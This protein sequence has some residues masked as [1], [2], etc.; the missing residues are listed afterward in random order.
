[1]P[2]VRDLLFPEDTGDRLFPVHVTFHHV[3]PSAVLV[4][5]GLP[6]ELPDESPNVLRQ[7]IRDFDRREVPTAR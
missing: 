1:V 6:Q 4:G 7:Q 2:R 3:T 5:Q